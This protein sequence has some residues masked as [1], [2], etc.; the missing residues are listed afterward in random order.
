MQREEQEPDLSDLF[1][2]LQVAQCL[3]SLRCEME[4]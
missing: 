1:K 4:E 3:W 2:D